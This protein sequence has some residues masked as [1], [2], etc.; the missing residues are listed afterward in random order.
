MFFHE[1]NT[2]IMVSVV[3]RGRRH[4][5]VFNVDSAIF[6]LVPDLDEV[7]LRRFRAAEERGERNAALGQIFADAQFQMEMWIIENTHPQDY[8]QVSMRSNSL[9]REIR[10]TMSTAETF[11]WRA[12]FFQILGVLNS[13]EDFDFDDGFLFQIERI[14]FTGG[15][16]RTVRENMRKALIG[17]LDEYLKRNVS[18]WSPPQYLQKGICGPAALLLGTMYINGLRERPSQFLKERNTERVA[19]FEHQCRTLMQEADVTPSQERLSIKDMQ[20][21]IENNYGMFG[22]YAITILDLNEGMNSVLFK[23]NVEKRVQLNIGLIFEHF[24]FIKSMPPLMKKRSGFWC[25]VCERIIEAKIGHT[26]KRGVCSQCKC[27]AECHGQPVKCFECRRVFKSR[28]CYENHKLD[29]SPMYKNVCREIMA[30]EFCSADLSAKNGVLKKDKEGYHRDAYKRGNAA[31][32]VCFSRKC[33]T[34][35]EK[36][37][38]LQT[39]NHRCAVRKLTTVDKLKEDKQTIRNYYCDFETRV[40]QDEDGNDVFTVNVAVLK[41][42][43]L[44]HDWISGA[45]RHFE[46]YIIFLGMMR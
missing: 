22:E 37:D 46:T 18:V 13:N 4:N 15:A 32:H 29:L 25:P 21:I 34:C 11:S 1:Q 24:V 45:G 30:C 14:P 44:T 19:N 26:C 8:I 38:R 28:Q 42:Y 16:G 23:H 33:F 17:S 2:A 3:E 35:G 43:E 39:Q 41:K 10:S 6:E 36:Y 27:V 40:D 20:A 7:W 5:P 12:F 31:Q 9:S